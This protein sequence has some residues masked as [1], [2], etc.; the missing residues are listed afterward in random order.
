MG[1]AL[2][3]Y[4]DSNTPMGG[5]HILANDWDHVKKESNGEYRPCTINEFP[6]IAAGGASVDSSPAVIGDCGYVSRMNGTDEDS[7][8]QKEYNKPVCIALQQET[9]QTTWVV[10]SDFSEFVGIEANLC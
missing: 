2:N 8:T 9:S 6:S 10:Q 4:N 3:V 5:V 7:G 1:I